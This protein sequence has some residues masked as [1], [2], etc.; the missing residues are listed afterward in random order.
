MA[1]YINDFRQGETVTIKVDYGTGF[2]ITG[3]TFKLVIKKDLD[4]Y[5]PDLVVTHLAGNDPNDDVLNGLVFITIT[6]T[7]SQKL[8]PGKYFYQLS[9]QD[10]NGNVDIIYPPAEEYRDRLV[11]AP[12]LET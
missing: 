3:W 2:D 1:T 11:I 8:K 6:A 9:R 5:K 12:N 7:D 4:Q 10:Q